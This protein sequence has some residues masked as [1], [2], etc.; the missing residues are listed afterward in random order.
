M[1]ELE[2][3]PR[4]VARLGPL[5][6]SDSAITSFL[7]TAGLS[8]LCALLTRRLAMLPTT[9]QVVLEGI[10]AASENAVRDV[11]PTAYRQV[12]PFILSLWIFL[13]TANL[14]SLVPGFEAPTR[15]LS[16]TSALAVLVFLSVHWFG[17]RNQGLRA[18]L[19][20]YLSP[21][22]ILLPF[23]LISEVTRTMAL[24]V[25]LFGNML[26]MDLIA[27]LLLL[28]A[29]LFVPI[30]IMLLHIVEGLVQAY[31]FGVLALVYI[32]GGIQSG[33]APVDAP[34]EEPRHE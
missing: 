20:H 4:V 14:I 18:Y 19:R 21:N 33:P 23:H 32:A 12:T 3:F 30:P 26:S 28:I 27:L 9:L 7:L 22:P 11:L 15:D 13:A 1:Q 24:A 2:F 29:G 34:S 17:I 6:I 16:V 25:R 31:I 8:G 10:V 5:S